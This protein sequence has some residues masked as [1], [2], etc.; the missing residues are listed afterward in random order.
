[1][2]QTLQIGG[3]PVDV[4]SLA[5]LRQRFEV[6]QLMLFGSAARGEMGPD[7]D[8]N[9]LVEF[10][11]DSKI[12]LVAYAGLMLELTRP[13]GRKADLASEARRKRMLGGEAL[14]DSRLLYAA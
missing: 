5:D 13:W 11:P 14:R 6:G 12:D 4:E 10:L 7:C 3:G 9:L 8:I 1:M 2:A